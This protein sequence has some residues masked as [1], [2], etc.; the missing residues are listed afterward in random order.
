M[1]V[2][3]AGQPKYVEKVVDVLTH[4]HPE[5]FDAVWD[6]RH[7]RVYGDGTITK[8]LYCIGLSPETTIHLD[9]DAGVLQ[10][11]PE[12][13]L[14]V[15]PFSPRSEKDVHCDDVMKKAFT[16]IHKKFR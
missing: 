7:C 16:H 4:G 2:Y 5:V 10:E 9:D 1:E 11:N 12:C 15:P 6:Y 14:L 8:P 3:S 13:G